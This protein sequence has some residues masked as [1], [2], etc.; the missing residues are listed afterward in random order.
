MTRITHDLSNPRN[1]RVCSVSQAIYEGLVGMDVSE[2]LDAL[3]T[4][5]YLVHAGLMADGQDP[6]PV[7]RAVARLRGLMEERRALWE[8]DVAGSA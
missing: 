4:A 7:E 6:A 8:A 3:A 2:A 1:A 5:F